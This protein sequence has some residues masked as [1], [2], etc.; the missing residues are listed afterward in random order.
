MTN[1]HPSLFSPFMLTEKI[2]LRNRI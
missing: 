1:K 2:K